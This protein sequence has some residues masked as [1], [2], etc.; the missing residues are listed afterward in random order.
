MQLYDALMKPSISERFPAELTP[1]SGIG[2]LL[3]QIEL[4]GADASVLRNVSNSLDEI[5]RVGTGKGQSVDADDGD[6][7]LTNTWA[8][9]HF[10][11]GK[12]L[13][14]I[15]HSHL[16][17]LADLC[18]LNGFRTFGLLQPLVVVGYALAAPI[19]WLV[20]RGHIN[21]GDPEFYRKQ[22]LGYIGIARRELGPLAQTRWLI[23]TR[24]QIKAMAAQ[25]EDQ[26]VPVLRGVAS[27]LYDS[28]YEG[29]GVDA[30]SAMSFS[31]PASISLHLS[32]TALDQ[33]E[34]HPEYSERA[35]EFRSFLSRNRNVI[36]NDHK[37]TLSAAEFERLWMFQPLL[38]AIMREPRAG[39][40]AIIDQT[41]AKLEMAEA[42]NEIGLL[43][44][45]GVENKV[46]I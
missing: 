11:K 15:S 41:I 2:P 23:A 7:T 5:L 36:E 43:N 22:L 42:R 4:L 37:L 38:K 32:E 8:Y 3:R 14:Y 30:L 25:I 9:K 46:R 12:S 16:Q 21:A 18:S 35:S 27:D 17:G 39:R 13:G 29:L 45:A 20:E 33:I 28:K 44:V 10:A 19:G 24:D 1:A 26:V 34:H 40:P 31:G 6:N